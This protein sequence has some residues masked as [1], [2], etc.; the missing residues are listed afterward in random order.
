MRTKKEEK[1]LLTLCMSE[2]FFPEKKIK[3]K[4]KK[5]SLKM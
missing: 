3:R 5:K 1:F 4:E 2:D